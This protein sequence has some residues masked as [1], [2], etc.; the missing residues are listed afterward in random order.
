LFRLAQVRLGALLVRLTFMTLGGLDI[1][2]RAVEAGWKKLR[3]RLKDTAK[4]CISKKTN[5]YT[6]GGGAVICHRLAF[7][8]IA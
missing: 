8:T 4:V 2:E 1:F 3:L 7:V 6:A 5:M